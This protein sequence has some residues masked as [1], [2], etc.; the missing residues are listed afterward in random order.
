MMNFTVLCAQSQNT[1]LP[2]P[3]GSTHLHFTN[4]KIVSCQQE[5]ILNYRQI[6]YEDI[7]LGMIFLIFLWVALNCYSSMLCLPYLSYAQ[8]FPVFAILYTHFLIFLPAKL[9]S[10][11]CQCFWINWDRVS[12]L[13][14]TLIWEDFQIDSVLFPSFGKSVSRECQMGFLLLQLG[15]LVMDQLLSSSS[16]CNNKE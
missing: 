2:Q 5:I 9:V 1:S 7:K 10:A 12:W 8:A 16:C 11:S 4:L 15:C 13:A 6:N 14:T 3:N